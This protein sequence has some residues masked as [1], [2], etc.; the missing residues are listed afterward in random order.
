[1]IGKRSCASTCEV[2]IS[3]RRHAA[4]P[5]ICPALI[6]VGMLMRDYVLAFTCS[7]RS[8][9]AGATPRYEARLRPHVSAHLTFHKNAGSRGAP[10]LTDHN[11]HPKS[12]DHGVDGRRITFSNSSPLGTK[13]SKS[14]VLIH[15]SMRSRASAGG[16]ASR[17]M[18]RMTSPPASS[19]APLTNT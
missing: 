3:T 13:L 2:D 10:S 18:S 6:L 11:I 16:N 14:M 12:F 4:A 9:L 5:F 1:M 8:A 7:A 15:R 17:T 19:R